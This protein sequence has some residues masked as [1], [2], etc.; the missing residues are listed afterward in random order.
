M[1]TQCSAVK[2]DRRCQGYCT[3][4]SPFCFFHKSKST[5]PDDTADQTAFAAQETEASQPK[6]TSTLPPDTPD[7]RLLSSYDVRDFI[8]Q[9]LNQIRTGRMSTTVGNCLF[10]GTG[11]LLR[12]IEGSELEQRIEA[13]EAKGVPLRRT[14]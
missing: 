12:A 3:K 10:I 7:V 13:L 4:N 1:P 2:N 5:P 6:P 9:T 14:A 11:V 8:A